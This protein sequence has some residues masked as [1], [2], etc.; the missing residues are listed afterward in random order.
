MANTAHLLQKVDSLDFSVLD[1]VAKIFLAL[2]SSV[3]KPAH[4]IV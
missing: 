3:S 1:Q 4:Y 2:T